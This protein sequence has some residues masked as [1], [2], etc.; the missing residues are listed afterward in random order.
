MTDALIDQINIFWG[1]LDKLQEYIFAEKQQSRD[2]PL[3]IE[4]PCIKQ[5]VFHD[6]LRNHQVTLALIYKL[7]N[8][9]PALSTVHGE[10]G[11]VWILPV[12]VQALY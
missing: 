5:D 6:F 7:L 4:A 9:G 2:T 12:P 3:F 8:H 10:S 1:A 11:R